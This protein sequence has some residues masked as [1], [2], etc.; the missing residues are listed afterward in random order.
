MIDYREN[1]KWKV[2]AHI[3]PK[4]VSGHEW[5]KYYVG[6]TCQDVK[7]RWGNGLLYKKCRLF[8][9]AIQEYGWDN[10]Q[11]EIIAEHLTSDEAYD[12]EKKL[13]KTLRSNDENYGYN[14]TSG[15]K[16]SP[17]VKPQNILDYQKDN[18]RKS[19]SKEEYMK[20]IEIDSKNSLFI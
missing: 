14:L 11:N 8:Y 1:N 13:I 10:I 2:Y 5:D 18:S 20:L 16:G 19:I 17:S 9:T 7:K 12:L 15:G 4:E 6:V 3:V